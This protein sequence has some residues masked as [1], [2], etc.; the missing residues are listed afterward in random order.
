MHYTYQYQLTLSYIT[1]YVLEVTI[2][3]SFDGVLKYIGKWWN[4]YGL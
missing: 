1:V 3:L 4:W 2:R